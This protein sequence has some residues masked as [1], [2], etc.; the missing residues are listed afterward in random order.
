MATPYVYVV[1]IERDDDYSIRSHVFTTQEAASSF[2]YDEAA[3]V[4][5]VKEAKTSI[6]R[7]IGYEGFDTLDTEAAICSFVYDFEDK[8]L[9]VKTAPGWRVD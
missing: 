3:K 5:L 6:N 7:Y 9:R 1:D 8:M 4:P 2:L